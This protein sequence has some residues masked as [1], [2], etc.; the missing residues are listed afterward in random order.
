MFKLLNNYK[1]LFIV[2]Q[3]IIVFLIFNV[4]D[5]FA[6]S[7]H[8]VIS[9]LEISPS[10][11]QDET[12][13]IVILNKLLKSTDGGFSW[14]QIVRGLDNKSM[15]SSIAISP[16]FKFD[17]TVFLSSRGD[18]IYK[19][20]DGGSSWFKVNNGLGNLNIRLLA[21]SP[22]Y[23][24]DEIVLAAGTKGGLYESKNGGESWYQVIGDNIKVTAIAFFPG[25]KKDHI[26]AGNDRGILYLSTDS[27][28]SWRERLTIPNGGA[29]TSIAISPNVSSDNTCFVGTE[30]GGVLKTVDDASH[31]AVNNGLT[32]K[33]ITSLAISP[34]YE[35][36]STIFASTWYEAVFRS[37]D[38]GKN[39]K[40]YGTGI[41][42][43][44]QADDP[45]YKS[46]HFRDL[47]ISMTFG[48]DNTIFL[49]GFDGLFNSTDGGDLWTQME[50][51]SPKPIVSL[52]LSPGYRNDSTV[53]IATFFGGAYITDDGGTTWKVINRGLKRSK[54]MNIALS[55]QFSL[56]NT[57]FTISNIAFYKSTNRG[58]NWDTIKPGLHKRIRSIVSRLFGKFFGKPIVPPKA[59]RE[60]ILF[61]TVIAISPDFASD[62]TIYLG[63]RYR[64]VFR[65]VDGGVNWSPIWK[66]NGGRITSLVIS[67]D[68]SCDRTLY[69]GVL[70]Q[71]IYKTVDGGDTW[72]PSADYITTFAERDQVTPGFRLAIS[73]N[74]KKDK[75]VFA[76]TG[77]GL[78]K[79]IDGG[80]SW[81]KLEGSAF[82]GNGY[83]QAI[84][85]SPNYQND[86][87]LII[88]VKGRGLFKTI[89]GGVTFVEIGH[90]LINNNHFLRLL[91][92]SPAYSIDNTIYVAGDELFQSTDGG[93]TWKLIGRP[94]RYE[95]MQ[96]QQDVIYY[97]GDWEVS[98]GNGFSA[99]TVSHSNVAHNKAVLNFV[100]TGVVWIGTESNNQGVARVCIDGD[101]KA[102][103]D[104]FSD[105]RN[106]MVRSYSITSLDYGP[107][108]IMIEVTDTKN[109]KSSGYRIEID[110]F[111]VM[112]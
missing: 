44:P 95:N 87:T 32:A 18:G 50:T 104:Q 83:I 85:I 14:K 77:E 63:T 33:H 53:A 111:D 36:D 96:D 78:Y 90:D 42:T 71:G 22:D 49:G 97:Q 24:S 19:S 25:L 61:P 84:A 10:Y 12:L 74:Y 38:S 69:A 94:I 62:S 1:A 110:A 29:V 30:K 20:Q 41:T 31:V 46:R 64:G 7:P 98:E 91:E 56:D 3:L 88:T 80:K 35:T 55:P 93:N 40:K 2:F 37:D 72:R 89:D 108:T 79:T 92:F 28:E 39:W 86:R 102:Y 105:T 65:S 100:G 6:H 106:D 76:G 112:P 81:Q 60:R 23:R 52:A 70:G 17:K 45:N 11:D 103:V 58:N 51:L 109:P 73:P 47:R 5:T 66:A 16:S 99:S 13:F 9:I 68:F 8:D 43:D 15:L 21:V 27:G 75:I 67:P 54:L 101:S 4:S 57:M 48:K 26:L 34:D 107:H 82:G 59:P